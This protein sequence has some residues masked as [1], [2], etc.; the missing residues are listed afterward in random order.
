M[1]KGEI[2]QLNSMIIDIQIKIPQKELNP[3]KYAFLRNKHNFRSVCE[4]RDAVL[5]FLEEEYRKT[6][7]LK[8]F[9][10]FA[11]ENEQSVNFMK[12]ECDISLFTIPIAYL[13]Q[14][15]GDYNLDIADLLIAKKIIIG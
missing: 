11:I 7:M 2:L 6:D 1:T 10:E 4:E 9:D 3:F 14:F 12:E 5:P 13:E 8:T 15:N